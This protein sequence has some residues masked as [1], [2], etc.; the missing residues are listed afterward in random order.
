[1]NNNLLTSLFN[2][3]YSDKGDQ[4]GPKHNYS[5]FYEKYLFNKREEQLLIL[6]I[7]ICGGKSLKAWYEY[8]PN[9]IIIGLDIDDKSEFNNDRI[10]TFK[11]DQSNTSELQNFANECIDKGY[12]FD[13]IL[14]DGSHH[15]FDQQ[16]TLSYL[17]PHLKSGGLYFIEDLHTSL[18]DPGYPLY[19]KSLDIQA[20]RSNTT[21][22]YLMESLNSV[23][24]NKEQNQYLQ[25]NILTIDIHNYFN[26]NQESQY[27]FR[28]ITSV[29]VKK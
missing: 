26:P 21:L 9:A 25:N 11:L 7:G 5:E 24:L 17:F 19:G 23:Y 20:N 13:I 3:Y 8:F 2:K 18:A 22:F 28:S 1:M 16:V 6:E 4:I 27:K 15:M 12:K 14:D 10:F 29:L